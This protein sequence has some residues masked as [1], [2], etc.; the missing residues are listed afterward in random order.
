[1]KPAK[2]SIIGF[3]IS[4]FI[5]AIGLTAIFM[6]M[7]MF[8]QPFPVVKLIFIIVNMLLIMFYCS[9]GG[10][11]IRKISLPMFAACSVVTFFYSCL[12]FAGV[13]VF[14]P[15]VWSIGMGGYILFQLILHLIYFVIILPLMKAGYNITKKKET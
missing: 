1:M 15:V 10:L 11:L 12:Q 5:V 14:P 3:V 8:S 9:F 7:D 13:F 4:L 2:F 6:V